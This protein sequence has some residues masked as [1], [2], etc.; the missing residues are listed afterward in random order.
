LWETDE[1]RRWF[2]RLVVAVLEVF[3]LKRG[4]GAEPSSAFF[5]RLHLERHGGCSPSALRGMMEELERVILATAEAWEGE[6]VAGGETRPII[7]A[8]DATFL[9]R[10]LV[11]FMDLVSGYLVVEEVADDRTSATWYTLV[12]ARL[13]ALG[14]RGLSLVSARAKALV[15]LAETGLDC[16]SM[17]DVLPLI[18][19]L[20]KSSALAMGRRLHPARRDVEHAQAHLRQCLVSPSSDPTLHQ[21]QAGVEAW[22]AEGTRWESVRLA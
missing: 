3:G 1:G 12:E 6:G 10:L 14:V 13:E 8:V 9:E 18:P 20:V 4:V 7:G 5:V 21:A 11:G 15:K 22:V 19:D 16:R 2:I 17:P